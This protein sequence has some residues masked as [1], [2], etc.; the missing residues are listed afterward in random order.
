MIYTFTRH[1]SHSYHVVKDPIRSSIG[2]VPHD[3]LGRRPQHLSH[4]DIR[5]RHALAVLQR[6]RICCLSNCDFD[7]E[8]FL[9]L[10]FFDHFLVFAY[11]TSKVHDFI[12]FFS[13]IFHV[14]I[15]LTF[16]SSFHRVSVRV[17]RYRL[18]T[19]RLHV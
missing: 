19:S 18:R 1:P 14:R 15:F 9:R 12:T 13:T 11:Q 10:S 4:V 5:R 3:V 6:H 8:F 16:S 2:G 17:K 7:V